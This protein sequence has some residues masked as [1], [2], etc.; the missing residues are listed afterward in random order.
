MASTLTLKRLATTDSLPVPGNDSR[1]ES[2]IPQS[3][4]FNDLDSSLTM[5]L[6]KLY[7]SGAVLRWHTKPTIK[8]QDVAAHSWG[9]ALILMKIAPDNLKL[10]KAGLTHDCHELEAGDIPYPFKKNND[11]VKTAYDS[12]ETDFN[13]KYGI[14]ELVLNSQERHL[15]KWADMFELYLWSKRELQL[16]NQGMMVTIDVA[17]RALREMG[18]PNE[19]ARKLFE[20]NV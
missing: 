7:Q 1:T 13:L 15:L 17:F 20:E 14:G 4:H 11:I 6:A 2:S 12:Q 10:L 8:P 3:E 16:G 5:N 18:P 9:V 19:V